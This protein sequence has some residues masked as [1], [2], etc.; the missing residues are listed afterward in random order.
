[1]KLNPTSGQ[2]AIEEQSREDSLTVPEE[3][4]IRKQEV[5]AELSGSWD[6][7]FE[8][9][10]LPLNFWHVVLAENG[11]NPFD[12]PAFDLLERQEEPE[13][14]SGKVRYYSRFMFSGDA[15]DLKLVIEDSAIFGEWKLYVNGILIENWQRERLFDCANKTAEIGHAVRGGSTPALNIVTIEAGSGSLKEVLYLCG[16]FTCEY[17]YSHR[18]FPSPPRQHWKA[19]HHPPAV[20]R[21]GLSYFLRQGILPA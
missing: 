21:S 8:A 11:E 9:N 7:E 19:N 1:M 17:R 16:S 12:A 4:R 14:G 5:V 20:E 15:G 3:A 6:V 18:S 13:A 2:C 10:Q